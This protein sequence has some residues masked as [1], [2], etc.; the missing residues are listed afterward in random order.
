MMLSRK[1]ARQRERPHDVRRETERY[2]RVPRLGLR[3]RHRARHDL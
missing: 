2:H 3:R 1:A